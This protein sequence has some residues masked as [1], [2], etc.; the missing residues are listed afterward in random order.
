[1]RA[2]MVWCIHNNLDETE[3]EADGLPFM[4]SLPLGNKSRRFSRQASLDQG[5]Q[6]RLSHQAAFDVSRTGMSAQSSLESNA[7]T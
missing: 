6:R 2:W 5:P 3:D 7:E 1:M 4:T